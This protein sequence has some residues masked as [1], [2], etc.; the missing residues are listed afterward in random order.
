MV[1]DISADGIASL[2]D[3]GR[4]DKLKV[5][6]HASRA[7]R[8]RLRAKLAPTIELASPQFAWISSSW[9]VEQ[10]TRQ[11]D[12]AW[13]DGWNATVRWAHTRGWATRDGSRIQAH[14][15]WLPGN[16]GIN[17]AAKTGTFS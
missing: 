13:M 14:V 17:E 9:I 16:S 15:E 11:D 4:M 6:V 12:A 5:V 3:A 2:L 8:E 1:V 7:S 10:S